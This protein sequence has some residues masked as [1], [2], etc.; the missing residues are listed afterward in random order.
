[1]SFGFGNGF[2]A[3]GYGYDS[4]LTEGSEFVF[5]QPVAVKVVKIVPGMPAPSYVVQV[6]YSDGSKTNETWGASFLPIV[7]PMLR[8]REMHEKIEKLKTEG[9]PL[10]T[11]PK[12]APVSP[13]RTTFSFRQTETET[14]GD[15]LERMGAYATA[16]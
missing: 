2:G 15:R 11:P 8:E 7:K 9:S 12:P 14:V 6:E 4:M 5:V 13:P 1:M 16:Q 10:Y 3:R